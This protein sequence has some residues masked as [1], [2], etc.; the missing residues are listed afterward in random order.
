MYDICIIG[1][2]Q[3]G[4][5]TCKTFIE[6]KY[7]VIVL[8]QN[9]A[10]GLFNTIKEK[11]YFKWSTSRSMSGFSD[12]PMDKKLPDWFTIQNYVDYL[13]SYKKHFN[14]EQYIQYNSCV[15]KCKQNE[16]EEW[17][18]SYTNNGS[19]TQLICKKTYC[20]CCIKSDTKISG[21]CKKLHRRNYTY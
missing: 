2:G 20:L 19:Q 17:V 5:V 21:Y 9:D 12:F 13:D 1:S 16:N 10:N 7:S 14:L 4:L 3:S 11:S 8:E 15:K 18:V 6:K